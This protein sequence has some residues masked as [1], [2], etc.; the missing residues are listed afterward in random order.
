MND[1]ITTPAKTNGQKPRRWTPVDLFT[2]LQ[3]EMDRFWG[4]T[5]FASR[6]LGRVADQ[7][8]SAMPRADVFEQNGNIVVKAELPGIKVEDIDLTIDSGDLVIRA[9]R[10]SETEVKE[11]DYYRMERTAGSF[12]RRLPLP[13]GVM[14]EQI[15]AE[16]KNGVLTVTIPK[17][18]SP[19][20][21][22]TKIPVTAG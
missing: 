19:G 11:E 15:A 21:Q 13:D 3:T 5:P 17:P 8:K 10:E 12:Y 7:A 22:L 14:A 20:V 9:T 6:A 16:C 2:D 1:T 4:V 18:T